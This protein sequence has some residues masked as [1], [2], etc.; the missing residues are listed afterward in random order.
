[1]RR[2][3]LLPGWRQMGRTRFLAAL[4]VVV[5]ACGDGGTDVGET[6][7]IQL[8]PEAQALR[9]AVADGDVEAAGQE[10]VDLRRLVDE[11]STTGELDEETARRIL[12]AADEVEANLDL[13]TPPTT[14]IPAPTVPPTT[15]VPATSVPPTTT[16]DPPPPPPD[17]EREEGDEEDEEDEDDEDEEDPRPPGNR[18][19]PRE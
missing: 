18:N 12:A 15:A 2:I 7:A 11:L 1:M 5:P 3:A 10:L 19:R 4:L 14:A 9:Q 13:L 8:E 6:A 16:T 17:D